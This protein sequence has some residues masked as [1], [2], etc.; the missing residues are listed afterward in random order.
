M[1][2]ILDSGTE[3]FSNSESTC[4]PDASHQLLAQSDVPSGR[5]CG[6]KNFKYWNRTILAILFSITPQCL[7]SSLSSIRLIV[8][9][10]IWFEDFQDSCHGGHLWYQNGTILAILNLHAAQ[11]P[12]TKFPLHPT[13]DLGEDNN[14]RFS[15]WPPWLPLWIRFWWRCRKCEKLL[16]DIRM[17]GRPW[18]TDHS[19][20]WPGAKLKVSK[21]LKIFKMA[22]VAVIVDIVTKRF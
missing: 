15:R 12:S 9:E 16:T 18:S 1:A 21:Q 17:K 10:Q 2:A 11:M 20:S 8:Q 3:W 5:R 6:L 14:C 4:H 22:A 13:Y 7:P 19:I